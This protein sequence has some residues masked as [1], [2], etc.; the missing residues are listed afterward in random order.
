M[1]GQLRLEIRRVVGVG[2][3]CAVY[4]ADVKAVLLEW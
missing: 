1:R 4:A 3:G 2:H